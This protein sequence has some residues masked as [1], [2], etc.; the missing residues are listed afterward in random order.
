MSINHYLIKLINK[1]LLTLDKSNLGEQKAVILNL[2]DWKSAFDMQCHKLGLESFVKNG[3]K[4]S[5]LPVLK[6]FLQ[7][8]KMKVKWHGKIL[9]NNKF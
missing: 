3:V 9:L 4:P 1:V 6:N 2:Y 7:N 5:L 8:R